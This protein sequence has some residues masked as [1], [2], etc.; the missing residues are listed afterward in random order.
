MAEA[1]AIYVYD[2]WH[3]GHHYSFGVLQNIHVPSDFINNQSSVLGSQECSTLPNVRPD[4]VSDGRVHSTMV[5][6][7]FIHPASY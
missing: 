6:A 3:D 5:G 4:T 2:R 7:P 1:F